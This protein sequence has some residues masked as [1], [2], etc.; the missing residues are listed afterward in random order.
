[1]CVDVSGFTQYGPE[2]QRSLSRLSTTVM[3]VRVTRWTGI[4]KRPVGNHP[5]RSVKT[6]GQQLN[7]NYTLPIA[8]EHMKG[9]YPNSQ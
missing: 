7:K 3:M 2:L 8:P 1:M 9:T 5:K 4:Y 6:A